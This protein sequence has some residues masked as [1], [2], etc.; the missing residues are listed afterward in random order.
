M[1]MKQLLEYCL[2]SK[3]CKI[4]FTRSVLKVSENKE[5]MKTG[6]GYTVNPLLRANQ[7]QTEIIIFTIRNEFKKLNS[8]QNI[9]EDLQVEFGELPGRMEYHQ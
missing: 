2:M 9:W 1:G 5:D 7:N 8:D 4:H 6:S 3:R